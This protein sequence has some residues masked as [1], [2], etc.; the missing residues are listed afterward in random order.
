LKPW[1]EKRLM[2]WERAK[3][4][5]L[6]AANGPFAV[7]AGAQHLHRDP[8]VE[9]LLGVA[10]EQPAGHHE[11]HHREGRATPVDVEDAQQDG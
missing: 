10:H 4:S 1:P 6:R 5:A 11:E 2:L 7:P 3:S 9:Q 8:A